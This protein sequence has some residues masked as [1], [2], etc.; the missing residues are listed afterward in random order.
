MM[1]G[2]LSRTDLLLLPLVSL[3]IFM[4][5]FVGMVV[6]IFRPGSGKGYEARARMALDGENGVS[7]VEP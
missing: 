7:H 1:S 3:A 4:G 6:W 5:V 2:I